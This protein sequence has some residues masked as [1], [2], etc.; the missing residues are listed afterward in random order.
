MAQGIDTRH[1]RGCRSR[2]G[3]RCNCKPSY[4]AHVWDAAQGRRIR[5][6]FH[7][8]AEAFSWR[9]DALGAL[10]RGVLRTDGGP[11]VAQAAEAWLTGARTGQVRNRSGD[12]YKP[13]AIRA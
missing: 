3:G 7:N 5:K 6:T 9:Q 11:T 1:A 8:P 4:Q 2:A 12:S 13:S 10:E